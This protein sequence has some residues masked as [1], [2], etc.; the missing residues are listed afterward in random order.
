[1]QNGMELNKKKYGVLVFASRR[2][3]KILFMKVVKK[4]NK[5]G[6]GVSREWVLSKGSYIQGIPVVAK[7]KYLGTFLDPKLTM[8]AQNQ[9][10]ETKSNFLFTKLYPYLANATAEGRK[11]MWR[12]MVLPLFNTVLALIYF[13]KSK[14]N[15]Y[16]TLR[17][18]IGTFKKFMMIPVNTCTE[19]VGEMIG[20]DI[21]ELVRTNALDSEEN[22]KLAKR[23]ENVS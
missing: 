20:T 2:A 13:E 19:L 15:T 4:K 7:Y 12:T 10:I 21:E 16:K 1:M 6:K 18:L 5:N 9:H 14:T 22:G 11:D 3:K 8:K 17:V 23:G